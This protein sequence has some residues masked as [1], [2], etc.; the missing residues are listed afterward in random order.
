MTQENKL[1]EI[2]VNAAAQAMMKDMFAEHELPLD[3]ELQRKYR[4]TAARALTAA[5]LAVTR[6]L[7][8]IS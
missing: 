2:R 6:Y 5:S 8:T 4:D 3:E 7:K 1:W